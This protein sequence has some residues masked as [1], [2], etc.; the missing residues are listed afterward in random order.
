MQMNTKNLLVFFLAIASVLSL[1]ANV[2][3]IEIATINAIQID[4]VTNNYVVTAGEPATVKV[5]FTT[6]Q[7]ASDVRVKAEIEGT[8]ADAEARTG[9]FDTESGLNERKVLTIEVPNE[10]RD[11]LS[12]YVNLQVT[13]W[14]GDYKTE[15]SIQLRI[16]RPSYNADIKSI[17]VDSK[18]EAGDIFPVDFVIKNVGYNDLDDLYVTAKIPALNI[19]KKVYMNDLVAIEC[20][21]DDSSVENYGVNI[22]RRCN[23]DDEDTV[24]GRLYLQIPYEVESGVYTLELEVENDDLTMS[25]TKQIAV[26]NDF[27]DG[28]VI[29]ADLSKTVAVGE[30]AVYTMHLANPTD[31]LKFYRIVTESSSSV[32]TSVDESVVGVPAGSSKSVQI[33]AEANAQGDYTFDVNVFS[34]EELAD[35]VALALKAEGNSVTSVK[36][37]VVILTVVLAIIF[38]VLLIVLI[39][40]LGKKPAKSEELGESYY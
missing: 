4:G 21:E 7:N 15:Q 26:E 11:E 16:Q 33:T 27:S 22:D 23:E 3:A 2:S 8:K 32:S 9:P 40:L 29:V 20:D 10:L 36:N 25:E 12:D 5:Y 31:K 24:E 1:T 30:T 28:D 35:T 37:P 17:T 38:I 19:E 14:N 6:L 34:G 18:V 13:I 39:V